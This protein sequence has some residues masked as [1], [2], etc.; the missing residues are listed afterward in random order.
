MGAVSG[1]VGFLLLAVSGSIVSAVVSRLVL[2]ASGAAMVTGATM[3]G[4]QLA[5]ETRRSQAA[6]F[7]LVSFHAGMGLGP[8]VAEWAIAATSYAWVWTGAAAVA[9][10]SGVVAMFLSYRPGDPTA[11]PSPIIHRSALL[12]GMV[13]FFGVFV[14]NGFLTFLPLYAREVGMEDAGIAFLVA[15]ITMVVVRGL[16]GRVPD[17]I[18]PIRAGTGALAL[19]V[20]AAVFVALWA[21]PTGV[22]IGAGLI[23]AGLALQSPSF[24]A[25]AVDRVSDR[26]RGSAMATFTAFYDIAGAIIGPML[27]LIVAGVGYRAAFLTT[28]AMAAIGLV[29]LRLVVAPRL[30]PVA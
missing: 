17:I 13:T 26:E 25:L 18:G 2:G 22:I 10:L 11:E 15:S 16:L 30:R 6:A 7:V 27:G 24:I 8:M 28:A 4:I 19:T 23:S 5:P 9:G 21:T 12:P 1:S 20:G 29:L 3:L 14:F